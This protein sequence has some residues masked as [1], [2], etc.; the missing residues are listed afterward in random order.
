MLYKYNAQ[1][2][3]WLRIILHYYKKS[4]IYFIVG[5]LILW[6]VESDASVWGRV[7]SSSRYEERTWKTISIRFNNSNRNGQIHFS[8]KFQ[9]FKKTHLCPAA[10]M[11][12]WCENFGM[13]SFSGL[14]WGASSSGFGL[15]GLSASPRSWLK[16]K[17]FGS[18]AAPA[19]KRESAGAIMKTSPSTRKRRNSCYSVTPNSFKIYSIIALIKS[20]YMRIRESKAFFK[21]NYF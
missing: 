12:S 18:S 9:F 2:D 10:C 20:S 3:W 11:G 1:Y 15:M 8:R 17:L 13:L 16:L 21:R 14:G 6:I 19:S 5:S 4:S 7:L